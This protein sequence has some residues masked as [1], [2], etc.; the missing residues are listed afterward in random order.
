MERQINKILIFKRYYINET[1]DALI[2][3]GIGIAEIKDNQMIMPDSVLIDIKQ[4]SFSTKAGYLYMVVNNDQELIDAL[5][6]VSAN[7]GISYLMDKETDMIAQMAS[8]ED[9][10]CIITENSDN[11]ENYYYDQKI[12]LPKFAELEKFLLENI[13]GQDEQLK[14][15]TTAVY[16]HYK[17][18]F[19]DHLLI[20]GPSGV[21]KTYIVEQ[22]AQ[23]LNL[24]CFVADA[25]EYTTE[26]YVGKSVSDMLKQLI[27]KAG[28]VEKAENGILVIDEIDKLCTTNKSESHA[29]TDVLQSLLTIFQGGEVVVKFDHI[30]D[31]EEIFDTSNL[32]II[33]M[34][35]FTDLRE[36]QKLEVGF[37]KKLEKNS[38]NSNILLDDL[39]RYGMPDEFMGRVKLVIE[40]N[41]LTRENLLEILKNKYIS[42]IVSYKETCENLGI[43]L[44]IEDKV[45]ESIVD[46]AFSL[47]L[48][49]RGL[50]R[51]V[52]HLFL[53]ILYDIYKTEEMNF[54][55]LVVTDIE[56]DKLLFEFKTQKTLVRKKEEY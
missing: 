34:G 26:G 53:P 31:R 1:F 43:R 24:P 29:K 13:I 46:N 22:I 9:F 4:N 15:I 25:T 56:D 52:S 8:K 21:G 27:N 16:S 47:K 36:N 39:K 10:E 19:N 17:N 55:E 38:R 3:N 33:T 35:A 12:N 48:G 32:L 51:V 23:Y 20:M 41:E 37:G 30:G 18:N 44:T 6:I 7:P 2:Y 28:D 54:K 42:P 40:L 45:M 11:E 49:A 5:N 50:S 14:Q